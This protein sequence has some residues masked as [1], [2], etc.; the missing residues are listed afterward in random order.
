[1][2]TR[3]GYWSMFL[4]VGALT[5]LAGVDALTNP[6]YRLVVA[7]AVLSWFGYVMWAPKSS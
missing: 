5:W 6:V 3:L 7:L 4:V 2:R 1:M